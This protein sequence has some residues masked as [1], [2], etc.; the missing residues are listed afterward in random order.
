MKIAIIGYG[1]AGMT[2]ASYARIVNR[3]AEIIVFE[4]RPYAI[5]HPCSL[6]DVLS[7]I[8]PGWDAVVEEASK[9]PRFKL[10]TSTV[11]EEIDPEE[12]KITARNLKTG[13]K[14]EQEYDK[15]I[16]A[17]GSRPYIPRV[18]KIEDA[19]GVYT[20]KVV[21]DGKEIDE[22]AKKY[23][24]V[25]VVGGSF[26]GLEVAHALRVRGLDVTVV[27]YFNQLMPGKLDREFAKRVEDLLKSEG[28][29][30]I[31]GKGVKEV[32]GPI[33]NKRVFLGDEELKADFVI[34]CTGVRPDT[35]LATQ[36]GIELG[37][38]GGIKVNEYMR[39]SNPDVYAAGD[40][41]EIRDIVTGKPILSLLGS[42]AVRMGRVAGTNAAG[43][44]LWFEGVVNVWVVNLGK[45][46]F[47]GVGLT[48]ERA[49]KEGYEIVSATI[50]APAKLSVYPGA[51]EVSVQ[52]VVDRFTRR[53][54][55]AQVI[56]E[57][58]VVERLN[59][60]STVI[61]RRMTIEDLAHLELA[62]TPSLCDVID[63]L[64]VAA[65]AIIRRLR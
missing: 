48:T 32:N 30:V 7:G 10:Y 31:L 44:R 15:L 53:I 51:Y 41:V 49:K 40:N 26:I 20:L 3:Q 4:K 63:P 54:L 46:K 57:R 18:I 64:H 36:M 60:L 39:T 17:T 42:T 23:R 14:I 62:Y 12:K 25:I 47:G 29:N 45:L 21:E 43:G 59:V 5:Y 9:L 65:D 1:S 33:G 22:A 11:V 8:L 61:H 24:K 50:T 38:T 37:Q 58:G 52:L 34:M 28:V 27:E 56:G 2:A 55:G 16:L 35:K 19:E 6:P 13:E